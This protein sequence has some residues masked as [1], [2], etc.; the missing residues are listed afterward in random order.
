MIKR[1]LEL[2]VLLIVLTFI[3]PLSHAWV[4]EG[5]TDDF[6]WITGK[7]IVYYSNETITSIKIELFYGNTPITLYESPTNFTETE[8][9]YIINPEAV[10]ENRTYLYR[11][12]I[13]T[14][15]NQTYILSGS[16]STPT[17]DSLMY[18]DSYYNL[19]NLSLNTWLDQELSQDVIDSLITA[20]ENMDFTP[21]Q[22]Q[23]L[24]DFIEETI[25]D[26]LENQE[27]E[28]D[29]EFNRG[30]GEV[31]FFFGIPICGLLVAVC[32]ALAHK[33]NLTWK[34]KTYLGLI[35]A[36]IGIY[37]LFYLFLV[38]IVEWVLL[39]G[40]IMAFIGILIEFKIEQRGNYEFS[41]EPTEE[42]LEEE[43]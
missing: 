3:V 18:F 39:I 36:F 14:L 40:L 17:Y 43:W 7:Q 37:I 16:F 19:L 41:S 32:L 25:E 4:T 5:Q 26:N 38:D 30:R 27:A 9:N 8:F 28:L 42:T 11:V 6:N 10:L 29:R 35:G 24:K 33:D 15:E 13:E 23:T 20:V 2:L 31:F 1:L 34:G 12:R 21:Q 22:I